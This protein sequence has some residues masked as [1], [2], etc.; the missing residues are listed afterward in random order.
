MAVSRHP[1]GS[2]PL[3]DCCERQIIASGPA[4][5]GDP[6]NRVDH[7]VGRSDQPGI[8]QRSQPEYCGGRVAAGNRDPP[9]SGN[10]LAE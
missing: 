6:G 3:V 8:Q 2:N 10:G 9:R 7:D 5:T 4:G 1:V